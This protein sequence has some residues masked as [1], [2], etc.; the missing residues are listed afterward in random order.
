M[1]APVSVQIIFGFLIFA[2]VFIPL[3]RCFPRRRQRML[4]PGWATDVFYFAI[5]CWAGKYGDAISVGAMLFIRG[6]LGLNS[7]RLAA[8]QP[9]WLQLLE[10]LLIS[11]FLGYWFH[12]LLHRYAWPWRLHSIHHCSVRMDWLVNVRVHPLDKMA[13]D[14]FQFIPILCLG[15]SD[16]PILA[17]TIIFL[18]FQN[19]LNH[20]NVRLDF[21]PL[22][23]IIASP[24]FHHWHHCNDPKAYNKNFG[25]HLLL[26]DLVFGTA[27]LP[28][29]TS[30]PKSY[31]IPERMP[32]TFLGQTLHPFR[33][34][35]TASNP[36]GAAAFSSRADDEA[37]DQR[38][39]RI[40]TI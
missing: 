17:Y 22:R 33:R 13:G 18:G 27:Y 34:V 11:D 14:C 1:S 25:Q 16:G 9:W 20:S 39:N 10:I 35:G 12:R 6:E 8:S 26:W 30:L 38:L 15:F 7:E 24:Q 19:F 4:R 28:A 3:E 32:E 37:L 5:G 29:D 36:S 23:W 40:R 31:G 2:L 21:G